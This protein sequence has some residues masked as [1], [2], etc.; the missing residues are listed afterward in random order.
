MQRFSNIF[1]YV[2]LLESEILVGDG[3]QIKTKF[4]CLLWKKEKSYKKLSLNL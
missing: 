4:M 1:G 2:T 3:A